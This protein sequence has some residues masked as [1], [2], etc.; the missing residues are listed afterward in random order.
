[1]EYLVSIA[2]QDDERGRRPEASKMYSCA[3]ELAIQAVSKEEMGRG[4][5][6]LYKEERGRGG[7]DLY[8]EEMGRKGRHLYR[9]FFS[10]GVGGGIL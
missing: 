9:F 10:S 4:G 8:K 3:I 7:T 6:D 1:M 5:T 2:L